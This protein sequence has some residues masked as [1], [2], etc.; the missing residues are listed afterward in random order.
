MHCLHTQNL[1]IA[2]LV[3]EHRVG[4]I[5]KDIFGSERSVRLAKIVMLDVVDLG[6]S[7]TCI[8]SCQMKNR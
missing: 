4:E 1:I 7:L 2:L 3:V 6:L 8:H 5:I